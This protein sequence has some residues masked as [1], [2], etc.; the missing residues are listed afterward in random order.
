MGVIKFYFKYVSIIKQTSVKKNNMC[1]KDY[2]YARK[3]I[4]VT[5]SKY[6]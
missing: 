2:I 1:K 6:E 4:I 5:T 3:I